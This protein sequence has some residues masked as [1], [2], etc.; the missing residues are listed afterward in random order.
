VVVGRNRVV[1]RGFLALPLLFAACASNGA[2]VTDGARD[3]ETFTDYTGCLPPCLA[4]AFLACTG[5]ASACSATDFTICWDTGAH[6]SITMPQ[7][8]AGGSEY[9]YTIYAPDGSLCMKE[10]EFSPLLTSQTQTTYYDSSGNVF[11]TSVPDSNAPHGAAVHCDGHIY[12][13]ARLLLP[14]CPDNADVLTGYSC[15]TQGLQ[16]VP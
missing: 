7:P 2:P 10:I 12:D 15:M 11:A 6:A 5:N 3:A 4:N 8:D 14:S 9:E 16:C 13:Y 1:R